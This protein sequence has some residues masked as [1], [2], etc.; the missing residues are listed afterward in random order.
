M[1]ATEQL[2]EARRDAFLEQ[3][4]AWAAGDYV[5]YFAARRRYANL[6]EAL[7]VIEQRQAA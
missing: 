5:A 6:V 2:R 4:D 7:A 3:L 1:T